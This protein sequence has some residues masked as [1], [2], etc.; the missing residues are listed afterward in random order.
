MSESMAAT[1]YPMER[2]HPK[3][4]WWFVEAQGEADR[5]RTNYLSTGLILLAAARDDQY[6]PALLDVLGVSVA[7]LRSAIEAE[8]LQ[9]PPVFHDDPPSAVKDVIRK[10]VDGVAVSELVQPK[11][12]VAS[13]LQIRGGLAGKA[14]RR[15]GGD[16][17]E[18]GRRLLLQQP[19]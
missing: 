14:V 18:V 5:L 12:F 3:I 19:T 10:A 11:Q 9:A 2:L 6:G 16:P 1:G 8:S 15:L 4:R 13:M 17:A 7:E